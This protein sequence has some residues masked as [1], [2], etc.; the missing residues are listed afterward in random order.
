MVDNIN[1][2]NNNLINKNIINNCNNS[3]FD[4]MGRIISCGHYFHA[5]CF[6]EGSEKKSIDKNF[7]CP[8]C[9][10][11]QN[12][13]IPPLNN[14]V[15][16]LTVLKSENLKELFSENKEIKEEINE[17]IKEYKEKQIIEV[18][19]YFLQ[20]IDLFKVNTSKEEKYFNYR[21]F[22]ENKFMK[23]KGYFN[24]LENVFY[25]EGSTFHR[26]QQI[27]TIQN[28]ILS[29]RYL[30]KIN[31]LSKKQIINFIKNELLY[32]TK[33]DINEEIILNYENMY[34]ANSLEKILLSLSIL[35]D[36]D[37]L[38]EIFKYLIYI[39]LQYMLFGYYL[40]FLIINNFSLDSAD[41]YNFRNY[42]KKNNKQMIEYFHLFLQKFYFIKIITDYN[43]KNEEF[44]KSI[45]ELSI[46]DL[47]CLLKFDNL[48]K[49]E[50]DDINFLDI[51]NYLQKL[52]NSDAPFFQNIFGNNKIVDSLISNI[53]KN[54]K[55]KNLTKELI[56]NFTPIK[57]E[58][59]HLD[60]NIFDWIEKNLEKKCILCSKTTKFYY[61]CLICG[62]KICHTESCDRYYD[63]IK[64]CTG[65][66][67]IF[68]D[69]ENMKISIF[70][71][72]KKANLFPI[73]VNENGV[74]PN[75]I[76]IGN[77][78]RLSHEKLK[79]ALKNFCCN[80]FYFNE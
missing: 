63:H 38:K 45:N 6:K 74:G 3:I 60:N 17:E 42:L 71:Y 79:L 22:L 20:D 27:D 5:S 4:K 13:L 51:L 41:I 12:I 10:K 9:L 65:E 77:E 56:I 59:I 57:L 35:F 78:F 43:N 30:T 31:Y 39:F 66:T 2:E 80:D 49:N 47:L 68:I 34:Y 36:Y 50:N 52:F 73:Y 76:E 24:F 75:E 1:I 23:Y 70:K 14:F 53:R 62:N 15:D 29:L 18:I 55:N 26:H 48:I 58:F 8:L 69:M 33:I 54:K 44:G 16:K 21:L 64:K 40:R 11:M 46:N 32:L 7:S 72:Q 61:I 25:F 37:Q 19:L 28:I 67:S